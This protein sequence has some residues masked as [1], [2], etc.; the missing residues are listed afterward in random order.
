MHNDASSCIIYKKISLTTF[1]ADDLHLVPVERQ[2]HGAQEDGAH[3][4]YA[5]APKDPTIVRYGDIF[6]VVLWE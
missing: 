3:C 2:Q 6:K 4:G 1:N 5:G